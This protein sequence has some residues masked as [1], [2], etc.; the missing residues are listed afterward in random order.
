MNAKHVSPLTRLCMA[1]YRLQSRLHRASS[2]ALNGLWLGLLTRDDLHAVSEA[3]YGQRSFYRTAEYNRRG[4]W[5]W[6][7]RAV[8]DH[9]ASCKRL[10]VAAAGG[11]REVLA[12][13]RRGF[14][15]DGFE[16]HPDLVHFANE[17]LEE[18]GQGDGIRL[19]AWDECPAYDM[20]YDGVIIGWGAY[21]HIRG[22][23]RRVNL[24]RTL[25]QRVPRGAPILLSFSTSERIP[26]MMR[27]ATRIANVIA[28]PLGR[29]QV[30]LGDWLEPAFTHYFTRETIGAEL[31]D[32]GFDLVHFAP[33]DSGHAVGIAV[34]READ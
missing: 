21:M 30:E 16:A 5:E 3:E 29:D 10:L 4:L 12:L 34:N 14:E 31:H 7:S 27:V 32:G 19:A 6:E 13:R 20:M 22:R 17:F 15:V 23:S 24:L 18:E 9:F 11:G 26:A 8:D 1:S 25:R 33:D 28:R 2:T